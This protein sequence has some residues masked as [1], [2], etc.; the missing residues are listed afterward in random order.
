MDQYVVSKSN[1]ELQQLVQFIETNHT[2]MEPQLKENI[3]DLVQKSQQLQ[4]N[5]S[6]IIKAPCGK[7]IVK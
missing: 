3:T 2:V 4:D 6:N 1:K 7:W 5:L